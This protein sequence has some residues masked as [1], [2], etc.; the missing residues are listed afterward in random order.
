MEDEGGY[1]TPSL[2]IPKYIW[3]QKKTIIPDV[4]K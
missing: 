2:F 4:E 3:F 1:L